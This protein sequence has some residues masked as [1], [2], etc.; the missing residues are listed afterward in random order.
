MEAKAASWCLNALNKLPLEE[1]LRAPVKA[2]VPSQ[3]RRQYLDVP[4]SCQTWGDSLPLPILNHSV[5]M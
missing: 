5:H 4:Y 1:F 3:A 2:A